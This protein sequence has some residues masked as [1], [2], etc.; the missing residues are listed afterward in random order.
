MHALFTR[1]IYE[2]KREKKT[3]LCHRV[4]FFRLLLTWFTSSSEGNSTHAFEVLLTALFKMKTSCCSLTEIQR[5][6]DE[7]KRFLSVTLPIANA[8]T[9]EF[10]T[11]DVWK[12]FMAVSPQ[13]VLSAVSSGSDQ[14]GES[15]HKEK[16]KYRKGVASPLNLSSLCFITT[17]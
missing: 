4:V 12:R 16:G 8:H 11:N 10:Y 17:K 5:R 1:K 6:I 9:V 2:K 15:Q 13:D 7:V 14:Q 3:A